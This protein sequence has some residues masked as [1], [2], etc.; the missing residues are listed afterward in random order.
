MTAHNKGKVRVTGIKCPACG[1][2][3]WSRHRHDYRSCSCGYCAVDGGREYTKVSWGLN[4]AN[5]AGGSLPVPKTRYVY[6]TKG[7]RK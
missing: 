3:I 7:E 1:D 2:V 4:W 5:N 6:V